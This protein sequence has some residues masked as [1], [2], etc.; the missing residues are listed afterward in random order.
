MTVERS[1]GVAFEEW[2]LVG[3][4]CECVAVSVVEFTDSPTD[5]VVLGTLIGAVLGMSFASYMRPH[6]TCLTSRQEWHSRN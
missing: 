2:F 5:E 1:R 3:W 4:L 6:D